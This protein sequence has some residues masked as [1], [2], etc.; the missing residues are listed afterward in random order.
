MKLFLKKKGRILSHEPPASPGLTRSTSIVVLGVT[1]QGSLKMD[2]HITRVLDC[3]SL[4]YALGTLRT[5]QPSTLR[6]GK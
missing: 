2:G 3:A 1:L 5:T 4:L 6:D